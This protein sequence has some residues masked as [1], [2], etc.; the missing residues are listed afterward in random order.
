MTNLETN[1]PEVL[2]REAVRF[3]SRAVRRFSGPARANA[4]GPHS[5]LSINGFAKKAL[6]GPYGLYDK[7]NYRTY[8]TKT[9]KNYD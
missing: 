4:Y 8:P 6:A 7:V 1:L 9:L 5:G 2:T 3:C